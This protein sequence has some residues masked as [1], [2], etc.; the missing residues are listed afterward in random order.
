M[1]K[2]LKRRKSSIL[3][4]MNPDFVNKL[5]NIMG[6]A[7]RAQDA[8]KLHLLNQNI[9]LYHHLCL[10]QFQNQLLKNHLK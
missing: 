1:A 2:R 6:G 3:K 4:N 8:K 9:H 5:S 7:A 10:Y